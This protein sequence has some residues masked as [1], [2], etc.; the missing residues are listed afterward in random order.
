MNIGSLSQK[1]SSES[2]L[3][4]RSTAARFEGQGSRRESA[5]LLG[6]EGVKII[7]GREGQ[8]NS[9]ALRNPRGY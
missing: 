9:S 2:A 6:A 4:K 3:R 5:H 7:G 1:I 8:E